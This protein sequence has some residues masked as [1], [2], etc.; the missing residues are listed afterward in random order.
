MIAGNH[1]ISLDE[2]FYASSWNRFHSQ[3][4]NLLI[5]EE[6]QDGFVPSPTGVR[7]L[8]YGNQYGIIALENS[9]ACIRGLNFWGSPLSPEFCKWSHSVQRGAPA[10]EL[11]RQIPLGTHVLLTHG[12]PIGYGDCVNGLRTGDVSSAAF[13][14]KNLI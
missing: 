8:F 9:G 7:A 10:A 4:C 2:Q 5:H 13:P 11:W 1:D 6:T 3:R 14:T 12:P